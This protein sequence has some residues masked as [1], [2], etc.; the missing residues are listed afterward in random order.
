MQLFAKQRKCECHRYGLP[1][2]F[3]HD[4]SITITLPGYS[5]IHEFSRRQKVTSLKAT[6][7][8]MPCSHLLS[9]RLCRGRSRRPCTSGRQ[10]LAADTLG[11]PWSR[12]TLPRRRRSS[13]WRPAGTIWRT[14]CTTALC[15][16]KITG[17]WQTLTIYRAKWT[18][19]IML[20]AIL[21]CR[22]KQTVSNSSVKD[23]CAYTEFIKKKH[24]LRRVGR[25]RSGHPRIVTSSAFLLW[26]T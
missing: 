3:I 10:P 12:H 20:I 23:F 22:W 13:Y 4:T 26:Y 11:C 16:A 19:V 21:I 24:R 6:K 14:P 9:A 18:Y 1:F 15:R 25:S 7:V 17:Q 2:R 8:R 5:F